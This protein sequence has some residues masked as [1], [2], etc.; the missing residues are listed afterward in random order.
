MKNFV[1]PIL[2]SSNISKMHSEIGE[3]SKITFAILNR[4]IGAVIGCHTGPVYGVF[5][6]PKLS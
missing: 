1:I 3:S 4:Q 5:M 6:F 2:I